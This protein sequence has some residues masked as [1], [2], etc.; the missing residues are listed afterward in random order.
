MEKIKIL[1]VD[2][3]PMLLTGLKES[4]ST[5]GILEVVGC[6]L[7]ARDA[8]RYLQENP[9]DILLT[10]INL[11][12]L[13][14]IELCKKVKADFP[15]VKVLALT[16]FNQYD[17]ITDMVQSG[18]SGYLLKNVTKEELVEAISAVNAGKKYFSAEVTEALLQR[19]AIQENPLPRLTRREKEVLALV[20]A[21][22]T[23]QEIADKLFI[24]LNTVISHRKNLLTKFDAAN[25]AALVSIAVKHNLF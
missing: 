25:T 11:P 16:T 23:N 19:S 7:N 18:A 15:Q 13:N 21:G 9:V 6:A 17:F 8:I 20:A 12:D 14:G 10:D 22:L 24:S 3:H 1:L 5:T 4:L 2:D